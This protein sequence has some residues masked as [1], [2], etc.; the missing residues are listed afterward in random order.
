MYREKQL[1]EYMVAAIIVISSKVHNISI[2]SHASIHSS[3]HVQSQESTMQHL[4]SCFGRP[5]CGKMLTN[6]KI[7]FPIIKYLNALK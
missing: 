4:I 5:G 6:L 1:S 7:N 2:N 3:L